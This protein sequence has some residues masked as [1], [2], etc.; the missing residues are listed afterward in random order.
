MSKLQKRRA[1]SAEKDCGFAVDSPGQRIG[2]EEAET[3]IAGKRIELA[4][5]I[6]DVRG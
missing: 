6:L 4:A 5:Q 2:P 3:R 1:S